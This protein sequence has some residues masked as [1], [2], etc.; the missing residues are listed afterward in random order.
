MRVGYVGLPHL[1]PAPGPPDWHRVA[2]R[3]GYEAVEAAVRGRA[4]ALVVLH[5]GEVEPE[6]ELVVE[7]PV[8]AR[9]QFRVHRVADR[10]GGEHE[11]VGDGD[12]GMGLRTPEADAQRVAAAEGGAERG[13]VEEAE[14]RERDDGRDQDAREG[15][16]AAQRAS[17][18]PVALPRRRRRRRLHRRA[19]VPLPRA[20]RRRREC[21][22]AEYVTASAARGRGG[23]GHGLMGRRLGGA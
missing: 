18:S 10:E 13:A 16:V 20:A 22:R 1:V 9:D 19:A 5:E 2:S 3:W 17:P 7:A 11:A 12:G 6:A 8:Q 23:A 4:V 21:G 14:E 15:P